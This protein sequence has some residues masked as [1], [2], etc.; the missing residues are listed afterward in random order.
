MAQISS[1]VGR[2]S[3]TP[4][5]ISSGQSN[6]GTAPARQAL[7]PVT[8]V[9]DETLTKWN[10]FRGEPRKELDDAWEDLLKNINIKLTTSD[11][12]KINRKSTRLS[13]G[14]YLG[15]LTVYHQ[16]HCLKSLRQAFH[17]DYYHINMRHMDDHIDHCLDN[18]RRLAMCKADISILTFDWVDNNR[19][20]LPNFEIE[21]ECYNWNTLDEWAGQ[22]SFNVFD[23]KSL[24][25]PKFG[26]S[27]RF[28]FSQSVANPS[29][30]LRSRSMNRDT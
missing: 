13:D 16:L 7:N 28:A 27:L 2:P 6:N 23:N 17:P 14:T 10:K 1:T 19:K 24:I 22:H 5:N 4:W 3:P 30:G 26:K 8:I 29:Q 12:Q 9:N 18:L 20:P 15:Q 21:Q 11:L 25:H